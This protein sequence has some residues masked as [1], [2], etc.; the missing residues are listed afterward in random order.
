MST[1][2]DVPKIAILISGG[3][4]TLSN[5]IEQ[6]RR[7]HLGCDIA[8]VISSSPDAGGL[9]FAATAGLPT[10]VVDYRRVSGTNFSE[11][12]FRAV[13]AAGA[14]WVALGGF[15][16]KLAIPDAW[17]NRVINIHPSLI[18]A[19]SGRGFYGA[20]V[21]RAVLDYGCKISGCTVH[22][23]DNEYDHGPIIAQVSV[24]VLPLDTVDSLARRVFAAEC[25]LYPAVIN[26]LTAGSIHLNQRRVVVDPPLDL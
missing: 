14:R 11:S 5:L 12:I 15:L 20:K 19:F 22:F 6:R 13:D 26:A 18:P 2:S 8:A 4:T 23:V 9:A 25:R 3:G 24:P 1:N 7:G 17:T 10:T 21:H 16:R